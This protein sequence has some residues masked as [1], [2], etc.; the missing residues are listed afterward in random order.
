[1]FNLIAAQHNTIPCFA[2]VKMFHGIVDLVETEVFGDRV[3]V[4][5]SG[6]VQ[7]LPDGRGA[8]NRR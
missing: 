4:V 1:M 7:H 6:E 5:P 3:D 8:S 2:A